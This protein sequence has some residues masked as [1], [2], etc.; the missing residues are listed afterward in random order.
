MAGTEPR[1]AIND[2]IVLDFAGLFSTG[3]KQPS[4][5]PVEPLLT[6]REYKPIPEQK[7]PVEGLKNGLEGQQ[8]KQLYLESQREAQDHQ[9]SLEVYKAYQDNIKTSSQLQTEILKGIKAG[10][11]IY[12]LFLKAAKAISLMTSNTA[13]YSQ[14][15]ADTRAICGAG[16]NYKAPLQNELQEAQERLQRLLG[17][18]Q[19]ETDAGSKERIK[20][21]IQAHR[22]RIA[23]LEIQIDKAH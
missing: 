15:E 9:R 19:R 8:A 2:N 3:E 22:E 1:V 13:F 10:E 4:K 12:S 20:K 21:A 14:I 18:E 7:K 23:E 11:D 16:L 6:G 5:M 17:A